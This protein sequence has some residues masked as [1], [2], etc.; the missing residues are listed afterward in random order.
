M[1]STAIC[2]ASIALFLA[3]VSLPALAASPDRPAGKDWPA[4]GGDW[5]N[6]RLLPDCIR[7]FTS[8]RPVVLRRPDA[9]RPWQHVLE[10]LSGYLHLAQA[11]WKNPKQ[12]APSYN[13]GPLHEDRRK[14][15]DLVQ[16]VAIDWGEG[17]SWECHSDDEL[18]EAGNL[19]LDSR[20]AQ[21]DLGWTPNWN[22]GQAIKATI[23]WYRAQRSNGLMAE[24]TRGQIQAYVGSRESPKISASEC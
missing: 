19:D 7:A 1:N 24:I 2:S 21:Q 11:M 14:V 16:S 12:L 22:L 20:K 17:A 8:G 23:E 13:F 4:I 10:P 6:E 5:A 3:A 15:M 18:Y 9:V